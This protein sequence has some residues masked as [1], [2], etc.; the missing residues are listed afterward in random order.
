MTGC[1][2]RLTVHSSGRLLAPLHCSDD[3]EKHHLH[4]KTAWSD[5][6]GRTW[7]H[8]KRKIILH[9][10]AKSTD[11]PSVMY[12]GNEVWITLRISSGA[13]VLQGLTGTGLVRVPLAW[14]E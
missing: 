6:N 5:D 7:P 3:W 8:A 1:N 13:G 14:L 11:Y 12:R 4:V 2:D 10:P 9:D